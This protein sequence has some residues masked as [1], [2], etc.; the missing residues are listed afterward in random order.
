MMAAVMV[1]Y[2]KHKESIEIPEGR[3]TAKLRKK[4]SPG[5]GRKETK[6]SRNIENQKKSREREMTRKENPISSEQYDNREI[7]K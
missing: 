5:R 6:Y 2:R 4:L 1:N 3:E 7:Y